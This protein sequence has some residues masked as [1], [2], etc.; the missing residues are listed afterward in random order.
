M[1]PRV[2]REFLGPVYKGDMNRLVRDAT[3]DQRITEVE[4]ELSGMTGYSKVLEAMEAEEVLE[5]LRG[6]TSFGK[7]IG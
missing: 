3:R 6:E 2:I 4:A 1:S 7:S 5:M